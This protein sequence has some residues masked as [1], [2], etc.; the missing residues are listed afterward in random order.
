MF[1]L[2]RAIIT[3]DA[4]HC[5]KETISQIADKEGDYIIQIK[6]NQKGLYSDMKLLF[7]DNDEK[8]YIKNKTNEKNGGRIEERTC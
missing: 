5:Q 4:I 1:E 8:K 6:E 7:D 2:K 3:A